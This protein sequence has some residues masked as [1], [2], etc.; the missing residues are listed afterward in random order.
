MPARWHAQCSIQGCPAVGSRRATTFGL[1]IGP[2]YWPTGPDPSGRRPGAMVFGPRLLCF[3]RFSQ[4]ELGKLIGVTRQAVANW[5]KGE[6]A[7]KIRDTTRASLMAI[8]RLGAREAKERWQARGPPEATVTMASSR[9][10]TGGPSAPPRPSGS[11]PSGQESESRKRRRLLYAYMQAIRPWRFG[12]GFKGLVPGT[13]FRGRSPNAL[14]K[15]RS[16]AEMASAAS[17]PSTVTTISLPH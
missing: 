7:L 12:A 6:G 11:P 10:A 15:R 3:K 4:A 13:E 5:E 17:L 1:I 16:I 8:R 2:R 9:T 14:M